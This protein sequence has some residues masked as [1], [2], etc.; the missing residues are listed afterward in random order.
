MVQ[1]QLKCVFTRPFAQLGVEGDVAA[2]ECPEGRANVAHNA[3]RS[4]DNAADDAEVLHDAAVRQF[5]GSR[6][7]LGIYRHGSSF[8]TVD[9]RTTA[10]WTA[11]N[12]L[13]TA[14]YNATPADILVSATMV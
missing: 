7:G 2:S 10:P 6:H 1:H 4:N 14:Q 5:E 3:A 11:P 12:K 8:Q 13:D 9:R